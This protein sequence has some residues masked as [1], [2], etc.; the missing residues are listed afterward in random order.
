MSVDCC[1]IIVR[2]MSISWSK[3]VWD[4]ICR[5]CVVWVKDKCIT[6][7]NSSCY[8]E[9]YLGTSVMIKCWSNVRADLGMRVPGVSV[10]WFSVI[11][12]FGY[13][14]EQWSEVVI[15]GTHVVMEG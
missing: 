8:W 15:E 13:W 12:E 1:G 10:S 5:W 11:H 9:N 14:R 2:N 3:A 7:D 6:D 4:E